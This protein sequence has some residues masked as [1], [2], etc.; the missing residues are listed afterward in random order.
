MIL[1]TGRVAVVEVD[2]ETEDGEH[3]LVQTRHR[4]LVTVARVWKLENEDDII[5]CGDILPV[6]LIDV[7]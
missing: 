5:G 1:Y 7:K 4:E 2:A 3:C 6:L